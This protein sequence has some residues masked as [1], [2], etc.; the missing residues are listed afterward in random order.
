M[1][2]LSTLIYLNFTFN[3]L[4]FVVDAIRGNVDRFHV[5]FFHFSFFFLQFG[6]YFCLCCCLFYS[7]IDFFFFLLLVYWEREHVSFS[8]FSLSFFQCIFSLM[9]FSLP[10]IKIDLIILYRMRLV[11]VHCVWMKNLFFVFFFLDFHCFYL[12]SLVNESVFVFWKLFII[13]FE[14]IMNAMVNC[15]M[16]VMDN[17]ETNSLLFLFVSFHFILFTLSQNRF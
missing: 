1:C 10:R 4:F 2:L 8:E 16:V 13:Y 15:I 6:K 14:K 12:L 17:V 7:L 11:L 5:K 3:S 9:F